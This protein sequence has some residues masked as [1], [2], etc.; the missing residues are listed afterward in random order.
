MVREEFQ[1]LYIF[2]LKGCLISECL[3]ITII[4]L[5]RFQKKI[6]NVVC[7]IAKK[8]RAIWWT[9]FLS[10]FWINGNLIYVLILFLLGFLGEFVL[11]KLKTYHE[12]LLLQKF[13]D[14][15]TQDSWEF[16]SSLWHHGGWYR[17]IT[18]HY[19]KVVDF[20]IL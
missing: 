20:V 18:Y 3:S 5:Y 15:F 4:I 16:S 10:L 14:A 19:I 17:P 8:C 12:I 1:E 11:L 7:Q 6:R 9:I 13:N 2:F